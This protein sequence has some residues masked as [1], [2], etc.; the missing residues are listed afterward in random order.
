MTENIERALESKNARRIEYEPQLGKPINPCVITSEHTGLQIGDDI[1]GEWNEK[2]CVLEIMDR[3]HSE[4]KIKRLLKEELTI[5]DWL[6]AK[7]WRL[8]RG[9]K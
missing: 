3:Y 2:P 4:K 1:N 6:K 9:I 8:K 5:F 7:T